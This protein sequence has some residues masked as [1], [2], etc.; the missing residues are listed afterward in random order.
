M[1]EIWRDVEGYEG[2]Y[3][4]SDKRR[5]KSLNYNRT[6]K[7]GILNPRENSRGYLHVIL[8]KDGK[9]KNYLV[10]R[11]AAQ[12][13][14]P[15]PENLPEVN[16]I[17]ENPS[18]NY[19]DNLEWCSSKYNCNFG[20][21]NKRVSKSN[22]ISVMCVETGEVFSSTKEAQEKTGINAKNIG[23]CARQDKRRHTARQ[24]HWEYV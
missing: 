24:Y 1:Q 5:V 22:S 15:N 20:T 2:L 4:V 11:L 16:H 17:D 19:L 12:A 14:I 13:F 7:E 3:Q 21:R 18:N 10:H 8:C 23:K 6:G 9:H